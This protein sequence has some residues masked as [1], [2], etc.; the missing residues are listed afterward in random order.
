MLSL[1]IV[2]LLPD[3]VTPSHC[4]ESMT[5][6]A[7]A[8]GTSTWAVVEPRRV[9]KLGK[10]QRMRMYSLLFA[11]YSIRNKRRLALTIA[12]LKIVN[13]HAPGFV[14]LLALLRILDASEQPVPLLLFSFDVKLSWMLVVTN[15]LVCGGVAVDRA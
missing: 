8:G 13:A 10:T 6:P 2:H 1:V 7:I 5:R 15:V 12:Q 9:E 11:L 4:T 3:L 14:L